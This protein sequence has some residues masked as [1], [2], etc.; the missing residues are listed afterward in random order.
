ME[1]PAKL[2]SFTPFRREIPDASQPE[3]SRLKYGSPSW[4]TSPKR[5]I[6]LFLAF[7]LI[8]DWTLNM[9]LITLVIN[10]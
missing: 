4:I 7:V 2:D 8:C 9:V 3:P 10:S 5:S 6:I 1:E